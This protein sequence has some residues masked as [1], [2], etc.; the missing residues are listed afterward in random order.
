M[1]ICLQHGE[2]RL[3]PMVFKPLARGVNQH[4]SHIFYAWNGQQRIQVNFFQG[5]E[6]GRSP[7]GSEGSKRKTT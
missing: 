4:G 2:S 1:A 3:A 7:E 6:P 5:I